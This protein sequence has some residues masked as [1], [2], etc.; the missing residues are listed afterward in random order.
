[1]NTHELIPD[2]HRLI[3]SLRDMG[4]DFTQAVADLVDKNVGHNGAERFLVFRPV[5]DDGPSVE[6]HHVRRLRD[7]EP[8]V[9][10]DEGRRAAVATV[11][12]GTTFETLAI[13]EK[14]EEPRAR[15][16]D[17]GDLACYRR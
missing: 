3:K 4:Y 2:P 9:L 12:A 7:V 14:P 1:M 16:G 10:D 6:K 11:R 17:A 13:G 15:P 5:V 8:I